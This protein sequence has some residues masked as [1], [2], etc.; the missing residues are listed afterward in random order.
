LEANIRAVDCTHTDH[1]RAFDV[2][3]FFVSKKKHSF[4]LKG[5]YCHRE[6][7]ECLR[8][9]YRLIAV[10]KISEKSS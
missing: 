6:V 10:N 1:E 5:A 8:S 3:I 9:G 4:F 7:A 2:S